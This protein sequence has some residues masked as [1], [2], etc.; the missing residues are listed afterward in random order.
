MIADQGGSG[1]GGGPR[2]HDLTSV[3]PMMSARTDLPRRRN[4]ELRWRSNRLG[5]AVG[6]PWSA[7]NPPPTR[8]NLLGVAVSA[9]P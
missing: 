3:S 5:G 7:A 1:H 2:E 6:R 9:P 4:L 8:I